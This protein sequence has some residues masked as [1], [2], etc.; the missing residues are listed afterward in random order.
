MLDFMEA[1]LFFSNEVELRRQ[2]GLRNGANQLAHGTSSI[3]LSYE[4]ESEGVR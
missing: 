3:T 2:I 4:L 1:V